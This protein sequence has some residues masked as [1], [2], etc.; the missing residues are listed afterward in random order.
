M[1]PDMRVAAALLLAGLAS[2][3]ELRLVDT[4]PE[5]EKPRVD[6]QASFEAAR[7]AAVREKNALFL[8]FTAKW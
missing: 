1:A 7:A 8:Y 6:W 3:A 2:A 5:P 4:P